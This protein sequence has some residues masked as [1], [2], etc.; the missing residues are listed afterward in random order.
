MLAAAAGSQTAAAC[1]V[2]H[3]ARPGRRRDWASGARAVRAAAGKGTGGFSLWDM[4]P[5][6]SSINLRVARR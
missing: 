3:R 4:G 6:S 2:R 5:I 1:L